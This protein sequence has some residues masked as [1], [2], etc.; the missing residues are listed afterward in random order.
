MEEAGVKVAL[1]TAYHPQGDGQSERT[2]R[3]IEAMLRILV[4][5]APETLWVD[6]VPAI[7]LAHNSTPHSTT[8]LSPYKMLYVLAPKTFGELSAPQAKHFAHSMPAKELA[9]KLSERRKL[10]MGAL[11]KAQESQKKYF[12]ANHNPLLFLPGE[13]A[14]LTPSGTFRRRNKLDPTARV[15]KIIE[16]VSPGAY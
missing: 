4:Q 14:R 15:V 2:N 12:D 10:A 1:T 8:K 3:T 16:M 9:F 5:D 13:F 6:F 11:K 7:E